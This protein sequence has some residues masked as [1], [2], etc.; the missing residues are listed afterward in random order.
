MKFLHFIVLTLLVIFLI[1]ACKTSKVEKE[2][3]P[4]IST[5][6]GLQYYDIVVGK[7]DTPKPRQKVTINFIMKTEDGTVIENT[8]SSGIPMSFILGNKDA[9][10]G[11]EEGVSTMKVGGKRKLSIP[12]QLGFGKHSFRGVPPDSKLLIEVELMKIE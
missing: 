12:P 3:E 5:P 6:S 11:L 2:K 9:I 4:W 1:P 7:G 10:E 8:Y